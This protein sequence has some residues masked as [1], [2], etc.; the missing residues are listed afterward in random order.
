[1]SAETSRPGEGLRTPFRAGTRGSP[2]AL[3]QARCF[4]DRLAAHCPAL[5]G[6]GKLQATVI[7]TAGDKTQDRR[8]AEIGGKG[9]FAKEIHEAL[10]DGRIDCAVHSLKDLET[11]L[12]S[13]IALA[14]ILPRED[15]RDALVLNA[16]CGVPDPEDPLACLPPGAL[17][18]TASVR[19][20]AQL[21]HRRPD[22]RCDVIRGNVQRRLAR[23]RAGD[24][25]ASFLA[26]AGLK[27]MDMAA[28]AAAVLAPEVMLPAAGQGI[29]GVTIR[30]GDT[31]LQ[32]MLAAIEDR[33]A[34]LAATAE[35][36]VLGALDGSCRTPI[37]AH[38]RLRPDGRL[39]LAALIAR[40]DGSF[41]LKRS[42]EG[43]AA[44]GEALGREL[45]A[46]LRRDAPADILA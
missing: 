3:W 30:A 16:A 31:G 14:C 25:A 1:M 17:I 4:L 32:E 9:L 45:G 24:F 28:E 23:V 6:E 19:R 44:E 22:L 37:G 46:A 38:A 34:R 20:Q 7:A 12:P 40:P 41:L 8:L 13:G 2:L 5:Q 21:L 33:E 11:E 36:A 29:I 10:L 42:A 35:R 39:T 43:L 15:C 18:G 26:I 27:R